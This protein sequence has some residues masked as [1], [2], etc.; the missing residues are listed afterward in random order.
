MSFNWSFLVM[1]N[2]NLI[3]I[4]IG[5]ESSGNLTHVE[6]NGGPTYG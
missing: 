4:Q 6:V 5:T 2:E 1:I 3:F